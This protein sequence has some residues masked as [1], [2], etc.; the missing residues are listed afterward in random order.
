VFWRNLLF[1]RKEY[2]SNMKIEGVD[3]PEVMVLLDQ[4]PWR[5]IPEVCL[6]IQRHVNVRSYRVYMLLF[7]TYS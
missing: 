7:F 2:S 1:P 6:N 5:H 3:S 4:T